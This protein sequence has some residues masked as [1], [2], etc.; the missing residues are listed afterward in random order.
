[1]L[2]AQ[3]HGVRMPPATILASHALA[4]MAILAA[5]M[6]GFVEFPIH[7]QIVLAAT[8]VIMANC[9]ALA[10]VNRATGEAGGERWPT[11]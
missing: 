11:G 8:T 10:L 6:A 1:M 5:G 9:A 3:P 2:T 7:V 4:A